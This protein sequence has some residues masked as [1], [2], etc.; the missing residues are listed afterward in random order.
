MLCLC[1]EFTAG[2]VEVRQSAR[3]VSRARSAVEIMF[4]GECALRYVD[5]VAV[6]AHVAK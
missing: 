4:Y 5:E 3:M 6:G 2:F 1:D